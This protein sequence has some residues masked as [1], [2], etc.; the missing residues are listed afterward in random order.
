MTRSIFCKPLHWLL[1]ILLLPSALIAQQK[2]GTE[3]IAKYLNSQTTIVGW[4]DISQLDVPALM[5]IAKYMQIPIQEN[6]DQ[7]MDVQK[8]LVGLGVKRVYLISRFA[9]LTQGPQAFVIPANEDTLSVTIELLKAIGPGG[10]DGTVVGDGDVILV[11]QKNAVAQLQNTPSSPASAQLLKAVAAIQHPH[12]VAIHTPKSAMT[13]LVSVLPTIFGADEE[14]AKRGAEVLT[15]VESVTFSADLTPESA[16]LRIAAAS[17]EAA[18]GLSESFN[19]WLSGKIKDKAKNLKLISDAKNAS[20]AVIS[21]NSTDQVTA[22]IDSLMALLNPARANARLM[23]HRN[24]MKKIGLAMHYFHAAYNQ[25]P[26]QALADDKGG[27]L[28]SWRVMIL[29][30]LDQQALYDKFHLDEPWDSAHNK[31]LISEIPFVY[32]GKGDEKLAAEG[33]TRV[34]APISEHTVFGRTGSGIGFRQMLDGTSNT[35]LIVEAKPDSAVVWTKPEDLTLN[36]D[37]PLSSIMDRNAKGLVSLFGDGSVRVLPANIVTETLNA[38]L[39]FD[40]KEPIP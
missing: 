37:D 8:A 14:I 5:N 15:K 6:A 13:P 31:A 26:A 35:I 18:K 38:Y 30:Y 22:G 10:K 19:T 34:L 1:I 28:L 4:L 16:T 17:P 7:F 11:G 21:L 24:S 23:S 2:N 36:A 20:D 25:F 32:A 40:G 27:R 9:N 12:G 33:K 3:R 39:S 29:P